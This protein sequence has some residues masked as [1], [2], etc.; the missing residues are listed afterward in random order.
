MP[1][2]NSISRRGRKASAAYFRTSDECQPPARR[3][4]CMTP[5]QR[6]FVDQFVVD[7]DP[8]AAYK[9]AGYKGKG[10]SARN[11]ANRLLQNVGIRTAIEAILLRRNE[12]VLSATEAAARRLG[13]EAGEATPEVKEAAIRIN[14]ELLMK[15]AGAIAFSDIGDVF[16]FSGGIP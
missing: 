8:V 2:H 12:Q 14:S 6:K 13:T 10:R 16:D 9:R 11:A 1:R 4:C 5:R 15:E 3:F 7:Q